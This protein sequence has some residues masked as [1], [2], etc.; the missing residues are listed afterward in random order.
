MIARLYPLLLRAYGP[1]GWWPILS[2]A[3]RQG[4]DAKGYH[5]GLLAP[6][7]TRRQRFEMALGA[8]LT[9]NTAWVN[10]ERALAGLFSAGVR[11]PSDILGI[12]RERLSA[13][14]RSSGSHNQKARKLAV[15]ASFFGSP[16]AL[17]GS[18]VPAREELLALWGIGEETADT[19]LLYAFHQPLFVVDAYTRRF[20]GRVGVIG[21]GESYAEIQSLFHASLP[22][23]HE[24]YNEYHA[25]IVAHAK[26]R[27]RA[28]PL[29]TGCPIARCRFRLS[30]RARSARRR[31]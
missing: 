26:A 11:M 17:S 18:D 7:R 4:F 14:V 16:S 6:P 30:A 20:L 25:L 9:Q 10:V 27:C 13:L 12:E 2:M 28:Q 8:V 29:C 23:D 31:S 15:L 1:Q 22:S 5:P 19:I 21:G 24:L 3:G